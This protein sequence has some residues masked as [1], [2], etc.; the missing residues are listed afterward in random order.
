MIEQL[1]DE[2]IGNDGIRRTEKVATF[3]SPTGTKRRL[4]V[5][6]ERKI[7]VDDKGEASIEVAHLQ[8][9]LSDSTLTSGLKVRL[10]YSA[11]LCL[12]DAIDRILPDLTGQ[13]QTAE[14][15]P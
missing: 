1:L 10:D 9:A 4:D 15:T 8:L 3:S 7:V 12:R 13:P 6:V 11:A 5:G 14:E 2:L